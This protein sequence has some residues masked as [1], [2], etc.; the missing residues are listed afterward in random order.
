MTE[1]VT[2]A[3]GPDR[4]GSC[5]ELEVELEAEREVEP[6]DETKTM[7]ATGVAFVSNGD[8]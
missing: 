4:A 2:V 7:E 5:A 8:T 1:G 6:E 3:D